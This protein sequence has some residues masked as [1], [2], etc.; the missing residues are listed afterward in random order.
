MK[1]SHASF[2]KARSATQR[3][4][5]KRRRF[6]INFLYFAIILGAVIFVC[7]CALGVL[8]PFL[9]ALA[10]SLL[11]RPVI[12]FLS[13][14]CHIHKGVAGAVIVV[15]FYALIGFLLTILGIKL[16]SAAKDFFLRLPALY[17]TEIIPRL[18]DA[19]NALEAFA[20]KL[21]A[22][23]AQ[24]YE[25]LTDNVISSLGNAIA[26]FS[27]TVVSYATSV[28]LKTPRFLL[29]LLITVIATI[30]LSI[31][32]AEIRRFLLRQLSD[33]KR[34][35]VENV[36]VQLGRTLGRYIRSYALILLIT[37]AEL[38][39][40]L[41][42][43]GIPNA[44]ALALL[45]AVFDILPVVGSGLVLLPWT[46]V[47]L[48]TGNYARALGLG[49]LYVVI[50]IVRN[51][52][53]PKIVG[54]RVG[55]HPLV[56]LLAMVIGTHVFG[57]IGLLGLPVTLALLQALNRQGAIHLFK[58]EDGAPPDSQNAE[59][60]PPNDGDAAPS[61]NAEPEPPDKGAKA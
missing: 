29:N 50:I 9:V 25:L 4:I 49:I 23:T 59:T 43:V 6:I 26:S 37:F 41:L 27:K 18:T 58:T 46:I 61:E 52:I 3:T 32:M 45:I 11:L 28:T 33:S 51:I 35:M 5:D 47:T 10:V 56:T 31:D 60:A 48:L 21:D 22:P 24:S 40:G 30:F 1:L 17:R 13:E 14:R 53:E 2:P 39:I 38:A 16:V 55:L 20:A 34:A 57:G 15:L 12:R 44:V 8:L 54:D 19:F 42:L 7:R 36:R